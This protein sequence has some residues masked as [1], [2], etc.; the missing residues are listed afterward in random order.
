M[1]TNMDVNLLLDKKYVKYDPRNMECLKQ[2]ILRAEKEGFDL[3]GYK[4]FEIPYVD[5]SSEI[6][7]LYNQDDKMFLEILVF[8][9]KKAATKNGYKERVVPMRDDLGD[10]TL[11]DK[12]TIAEAV[13]IRDDINRKTVSDAMFTAGQDFFT[14]VE[15]A[16]RHSDAKELSFICKIEQIKDKDADYGHYTEISIECTELKNKIIVFSFSQGIWSEIAYQRRL[17]FFNLAKAIANFTA[18]YHAMRLAQNG[19]I[20]RII[21]KD[22]GGL[23]IPPIWIDDDDH[24]SANLIRQKQLKENIIVESLPY[25]N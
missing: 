6:I 17:Q 1:K 19:G 21:E 24:G 7:N 14:S 9:S 20:V 10:G 16:A 8:H 12:A 13:N 11:I 4:V 3:S 25:L 23:L 18:R 5:S 15:M 2:I 22:E